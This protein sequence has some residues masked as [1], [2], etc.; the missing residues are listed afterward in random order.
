[1]LPQSSCGMH[2]L[3]LT[4]CFTSC[5]SSSGPSAE[6]GIGIATDAYIYGYSLV[7]MDMTRKRFTNVAVPARPPRRWG[8]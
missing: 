8:K 3:A 2:C 4:I 1:M 6:D 5:K 7:T